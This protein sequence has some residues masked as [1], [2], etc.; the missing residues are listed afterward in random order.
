[1]TAREYL[2]G[3]I[4]LDQDIKS[5][6]DQIESLEN[7]ALNCNSI[8]TGMPPN[9]NQNRDM[10]AKAVCKIADLR[11]DLDSERARLVHYKIDAIN[12]INRVKD[13]YFRSILEKRYIKNIP[14]ETIAVELRYSE[15]WVMKL[16]RRAIKAMEPF[17]TDEEMRTKRR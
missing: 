14:W 5:I 2:L 1:M 17:M 11:K 13:P 6:T 10:M 16:H 15:S 7:L 12:I 9:P 4:K 3:I 8:L